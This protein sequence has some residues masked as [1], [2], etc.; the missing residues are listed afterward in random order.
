MENATRSALANVTTEAINTLNDTVSQF[1]SH[2][3]IAA[4]GLP[5]KDDPAR[6]LE[7]SG[8]GFGIYAAC[9]VQSNFLYFF[10][11]KNKILNR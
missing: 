4:S 6:C 7:S 3:S 11:R 5:I 9:M 1:A 10:L 2:S 8:I